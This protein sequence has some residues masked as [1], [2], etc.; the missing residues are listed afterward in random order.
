MKTVLI[1]F[2]GE[3]FSPGLFDFLRDWN[4]HEPITA[5]GVFLPRLDYAE[6]LYSFG[7]IISGPIYVNETV[8]PD[9][10]KLKENMDNFRRMCA[11]GGI[12]CRIHEDLD[13]HIIQYLKE[14]SRFADI[15][16][17]DSKSFYNNTGKTA[18]G[19]YIA[20]VSHEAECP[21]LLFPGHFESP[22]HVILSYDGS[23][24]SAYAIKQFYYLL[25]HLASRQTMLVFF[26]DRTEDLPQRQRIE[27]MVAALVGNLIITHLNIT[28]ATDVEAWVATNSAPIM[29]A[30]A[31]GRSVLSE[32][33]R[34]SFA[35]KI[36]QAN[37]F[38]VFVAHK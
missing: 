8:P 7:G 20:D 27:E 31:F 24:Q 35:A 30:G 36:I 12:K 16:I 21:V 34:K 10:V 5:V 1:A 19:D 13:E 9:A 22:E 4:Q 23:L 15:L 17:I 26:G 32:F 38:P 14:E 2:D 3:H 18:Q 28:E 6:L 33:F 11:E 25:P 37:K 29:V